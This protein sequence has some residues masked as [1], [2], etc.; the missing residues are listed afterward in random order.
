M[1]ELTS[2]TGRLSI[3]L[4]KSG[5]K[6]TCVDISQG[7]IKVLERKL[8][9][10]GLQANLLCANVQHLEFQEEYQDVILPFQSFM[11]LIGKE[12]QLNTL[13][14]A[15]RALVP[16]GRFYCTMH[17]TS[18]RRKTV[19]GALRGVGNFTTEQGFIVVTGFETGGEPIVQRSQFIEHFNSKGQLKERIFQPMRFELI[20][21]ETFKI[22]QSK[23]TLRL[24]IF[25]VIIKQESLM[26]TR[27]L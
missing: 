20:E 16:N 3:P 26:L 5:V 27:A 22:L 21:K 9:N 15:Y 10:E 11:E 7:M 14:A 17:N 12:R 4:I 19:D 23:Q 25:S 13:R 8:K 2:G 24:R 18:V 6:L 1:L